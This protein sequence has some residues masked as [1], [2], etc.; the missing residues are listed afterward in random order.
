MEKY[1]FLQVSVK[2]WKKGEGTATSSR[3]APRGIVSLWDDQ[4]FEVADIKHSADWIL[5][6]LLQK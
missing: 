3:R 6:M 1:A 4:K 5:S 2:F